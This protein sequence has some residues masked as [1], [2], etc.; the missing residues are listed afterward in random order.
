MTPDE[1]FARWVKV[2]ALSFV[3][4]FGY[5]LA[6]DNLMPLTPHAMVTRT[7]TKVAPQVSGPV[8]A[9]AVENNQRV[10]KGD[11]LFKIERAPYRIAVD[12]AKL[13]LAQARQTNAQLDASLMAA[14]EDVSALASVLA[15]KAREAKRLKALFAKNGVSQQQRDDAISAAN[16]AR[17]K[18]EAAKARVS[19]LQIQ[20]G[21]DGASNIAEQVALSK[22][23]KAQL[24]QSYTTVKASHDGVVTN[25]QLDVGA[26]ASAGK[27]LMALVSERA[28]V[29]A[30]FREKSVRD[31]QTGTAVNVTFDS[32]PG[33][34]YAGH[35][36]S[37]DAGVSAGQIDANGQLASPS[38]SNRWVRDAQRIR[39][40]IQLDEWPDHALPTGARAT[41]QI[42]PES[43]V[44]QWLASAQVGF[45]SMLHYIY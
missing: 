4:I 18:W 25:L 13:A 32:E 29:I 28:D 14:R 11:V 42:M 2:A 36:S 15:Q 34:L 5:F 6:A 3:L 19:A 8:S 23:K 38:N 41:V 9:L 1:K 39:L 37:V 33:K 17:A 45:L 12:Q 22:L 20:R 40:H 21:G 16:T 26:Y 30:D 10:Q 7:V 27:P 35:V 24:N 44:T 43:A 31:V